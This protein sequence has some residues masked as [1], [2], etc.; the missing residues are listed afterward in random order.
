M[1][2]GSIPVPGTSEVESRHIL[3]DTPEIRRENQAKF[4]IEK[5]V[6]PHDGKEVAP[7]S[8]KQV[9]LDD[10][11][12]VVEHNVRS[13]SFAK[14]NH[15]T[16][17]A[18]HHDDGRARHSRRKWI[19]LCGF[20][21]LIVILSV[22]LGPVFGLRHKGSEKDSQNNSPTTS[23]TSSPTLPT[24]TLL[25]P[26]FERNIAAFSFESD[27]TSSQRVNTSRV[28]FQ[29]NS[30]RLLQAS[31]SAD[32]TSWTL[33]KTPVTPRNGSAIGAAVSRPGYAQVSHAR[34]Y[35]S[36]I[37]DPRPGVCCLLSQ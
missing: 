2:T 12:Q 33:S 36:A 34:R 4:Y 17:G 29:D 19:V 26:L 20:L 25:S 30:G 9:S 14:E 10:G 1:V 31:N 35:L 13:E 8:G 23:V 6:L 7:T 18:D 3:N 15:P 27:K 37:I 24:P 28:Y 32:K 16:Q 5:Q 22:I 21:A 11:K